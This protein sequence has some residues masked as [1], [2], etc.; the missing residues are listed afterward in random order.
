M[1]QVLSLEH[2]DTKPRVPSALKKKPDLAVGVGSRFKRAE[3]RTETQTTKTGTNRVLLAGRQNKK[4]LGDVGAAVGN[5]VGKSMGMGYGMGPP[6]VDPLHQLVGG[7]WGSIHGY[8]P[9]QGG[10]ANGNNW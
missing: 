5:A 10:M 4:F 1:L 2:H 8:M 3:K 9:P 6:G 7:N